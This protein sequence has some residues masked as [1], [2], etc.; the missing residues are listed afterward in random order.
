MQVT[1]CLIV[2][3]SAVSVVIA[4]ILL[5]RLHPIIGLVL[6][7]LVIL[8][9]TQGQSELSVASRL[10]SGMTEIFEKIG[11][12]IVFAS[13]V[14]GCLLESGAAHRI[15]ADIVRLFGSQRVAPALSVS[16]FIM[17]IPV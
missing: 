4:S 11:L 5:L 9:Y 7:T 8:F 1:E 6:G 2:A 3:F 10:A 14:G 16:A 13:I 12:P 17:A 15:V